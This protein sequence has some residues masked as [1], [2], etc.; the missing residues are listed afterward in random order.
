MSPSILLA[1]SDLYTFVVL[2]MRTAPTP[3]LVDLNTWSPID[4]PVW[5]GLGGIA[6]LEQV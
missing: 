4:D 5:E 1:F 3:R 2:C 6:L